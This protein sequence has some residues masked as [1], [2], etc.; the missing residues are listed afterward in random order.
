MQNVEA[1]GKNDRR[2]YAFH[3]LQFFL[4]DGKTKVADKRENNFQIIKIDVNNF[5]S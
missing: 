4:N 5:L 1:L 3:I 2:L